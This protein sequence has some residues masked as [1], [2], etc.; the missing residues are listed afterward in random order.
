MD[1]KLSTGDTE[2]LRPPPWTDEELVQQFQTNH[3]LRPRIFEVLYR[4][5]RQRLVCFLLY[6]GIQDYSLAEDIVAD[7]FV[8]LHQGA[9]DRFKAINFRAWIYTITRRRF[10][11]QCRHR[12]AEPL[13]SHDVPD[14]S[15]TVLE[16][17]QTEELR[18]AVRQ[19][20]AQLD[21]Q[22]RE[23]MNLYYFEDWTLAEIAQRLNTS[24]P[25]VFRVLARARAKVLVWL[26]ADG[27][28]V[29]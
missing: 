14:V 15:S 11:D 13:D 28:D 6:Q 4:K 18:S 26:Q 25:T 8:R 19:A 3:A 9:L 22:Q 1:E 20:I 27:H 29:A 24:A 7:V 10:L 16:A 2:E 17:I 21:P 12:A 5:Y 23:A